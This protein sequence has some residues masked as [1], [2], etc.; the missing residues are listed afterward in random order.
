MVIGI[1]ASRANKKQRTGTEWYSYF[2]IEE[3][4]KIANLSLREAERRSNLELDTAGLPRPAGGG[5]RDDASHR[6]ILY[7]KEPLRDGLEKLPANFES[8]ILKWPFRFFWTQCRMSWEMSTRP[9]DVLFVPAHALPVFCRVKTVV[10]IHDVGFR[11][12]PRLYSYKDKL[13]HRFAVWFASR[14][15]SRIICPSEFSRR[16]LEKYYPHAA[17]K[18]AVVPHGFGE[19]GETARKLDIDHPFFLFVG[20]LEEKKNIL[21]IVAAFELFQKKYPR[22]RLQLAGRPGYGF[23]RVEAYIKEHNLKDKVLISGYLPEIR[24]NQLYASASAF[25]FPTF[26]EGF[27]LPI[28]EAQARK[29][30]VVTANRGA[31]AE[32]AGDGAFLV[33][34]E[35]PKKICE[36]LQAIIESE[37]LRGDLTAKG[38]KNVIR[39]T[40]AASAK[41]TLKVIR[42]LA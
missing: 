27:G 3:L 5:A 37:S 28:L 39:Y 16:D 19:T 21:N 26:Y 20:R 22:F 8:R 7:S 35:N 29:C 40:W 1:D 12:L 36:A 18:I 4:K 42:E 17:G 41:N 10:T 25:V 2:L 34:P 32:I 31:N 15:A 6:F 38:L 33:D 30:P 14:F 23:K 11:A 13:Y 24:K 9:P